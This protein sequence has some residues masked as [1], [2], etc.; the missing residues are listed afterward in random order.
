MKL[1]EVVKLINSTLPSND[2]LEVAAYSI[3]SRTIGQREIFFAIRGEKFDGHEFVEKAF[4][5]GAIA[6]VVSKQ[7][8]ATDRVA[9]RLIR[10]EDTLEALQN[11]AKNLLKTWNRP[12]I[13]ITGS[14]GKTT[15][16]ELTSLVLE[17]KG[18]VMRSSGNFN[19]A[20]GLPLSVLQMESRGQKAT[21]FDFTVLEMGMSS[22][23]EITRLCHIAPPDIAAVLNVGTAHI[24]FLGSQQAIAE[25]KAEIVEGLK[26]GGT[27]VLNNDDSFVRAMRSKHSGSILMFGIESEADIRAVE[28]KESSLFGTEFHLVTPSGSTIAYLPLPGRHVLYNALVAAAV[29]HHFGLSPEEI[30]SQL[31][32]A[33]PAKHR[34]DV[35]KFDKG[36]TLVDDSYNSSPDALKQMI[37]TIGQATGFARKIIVTG[38][39]L[40][41]GQQSVELHREAGRDAANIS[42][43]LLVGIQ[44]DAKHTIEAAKENGIAAEKLLF[45]NSSEEAIEPIIERVR[46]GDLILVKGSRGVKTD[47]IV[48]AIKKRFEIEKGAGA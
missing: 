44:G 23:G 14:A 20:Y 22:K 39:M 17:A 24:E 28:L 30:A 1:S 19:N 12:I 33:R 21:D 32:Q 16:K 4:E 31:R 8:Q 36:F 27:A 42:V 18:S 35:V 47:I 6:A 25:A 15:T 40:E 34:M 3:D 38:E 26:P 46:P 41:L 10:V 48:E 9:H 13:G 29:G 5:K 2:D 7:Y 37:K 45:F 43:D 11:L